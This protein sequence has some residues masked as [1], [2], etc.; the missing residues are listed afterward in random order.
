MTEDATSRA[1][2]SDDGDAT[3]AGGAAKPKVV[4]ARAT[5]VGRTTRR[6]ASD[7]VSAGATTPDVAPA[8]ETTA[9]DVTAPATGRSP[10]AV[11]D[12]APAGDV[13]T[14]VGDGLEVATADRITLT[15]GGI[16]QANAAA[17]DVTQ[18]GIGM[19]RATD[20]ALAKGG[21]GFARGDRVSVEMGAVGLAL[22]D[23]A[24]VS[25]G[26]VRNLLGREVRIE[27]AGVAAVAAAH[28]TIERT[29]AVGI[30]IAGR[31]DGAVRPIL[32][33]RGALA[34]GAAIGLVARLLR[35]R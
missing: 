35:R 33:W 10:V 26:L 12:P 28:V 5:T 25:Q 11:M 15:Q 4:R 18:G 21:I 22:A 14:A 17:I 29:T 2:T 27:Q 20:I 31:V 23:E 16:G 13:P 32:D 6:S 19:A 9:A 1:S 34:L 8:A 3:P 30:L 7:K 24:R